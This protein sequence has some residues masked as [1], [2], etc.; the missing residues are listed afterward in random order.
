MKS[1]PARPTVSN[2]F[3]A[4]TNIK[5][6]KFNKICLDALGSESCSKKTF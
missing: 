3:T 2:W 1:P 4:E 5:G 6:T